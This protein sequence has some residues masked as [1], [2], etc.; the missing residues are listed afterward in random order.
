[1]RFKIISEVTQIETI[2]RGTGVKARQF[3]NATYGQG[4][5]RKMKGL[6]VVEYE[7]GEIWTVE[8][9]WY[10]ANGIGRKREK[11]KQRIRRIR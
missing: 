6:A 2:A 8:I 1:M 10:E 11:D 3:L 5:W 9:H 7:N 4:N